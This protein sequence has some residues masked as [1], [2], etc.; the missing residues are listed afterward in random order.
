MAA[1]WTFSL[2]GLQL[3]FGAYVAGLNAGYA[4]N[5]W[6]QMGEEWFPS[7]TPMLEPFL[8]NFVDNPVVVQF[9][10]RWL[11]WVVA[12]AAL[13]LAASAWSRRFHLSAA[14]VIVSVLLQILLGVATLVSGVELHLA[15]GHQAMAA[16]LLAAIVVAAHKLGT[17]KH[18]AA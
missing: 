13:A 11:A 18:K 4:F 1:A 7:G 2:L 9:V 5:S 12:A 6:P 3:L 15:V 8:V 14:A 16:L 10:H 17:G